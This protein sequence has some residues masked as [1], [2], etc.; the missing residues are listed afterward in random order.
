V[1]AAAPAVRAAAGDTARVVRFVLVAPGASRV[2]LVG[3]FNGWDPRATPMIVEQNG[4]IW[5]AT[6]PLE[7]GRHVY[8]FVLDDRDW[9]A[10][11]SAPLAPED[12]FGAPSSVV[13][14][15]EGAS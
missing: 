11:P 14:V 9:V 1:A 4:A 3:D 12:G 15:G 2:S 6:V 8:A 7:A 10:D 13:V 5:T